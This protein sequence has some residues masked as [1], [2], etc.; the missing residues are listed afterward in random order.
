MLDTDVYN[1]SFTAG[2]AMLPE[3]QAVAEAL[4]EADGN[5]NIVKQ[6]VLTE[7]IMQK[8]KKSSA[9][10]YFALIKQR[11]HVDSGR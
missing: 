4:F 5:W 11:L 10:R 2:A 9:T 7:N 3:T 1:L 6:R 8:D